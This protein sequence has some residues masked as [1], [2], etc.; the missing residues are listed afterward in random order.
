MIHQAKSDR[1]AVN[2]MA[3]A[4]CVGLLAITAGTPLSALAQ[5]TKALS[6]NDYKVNV[7]TVV[8]GL[9][10]PWG[11]AFLP[12]GR[13]LI[14][15][16][17]G[18]MR[19][20]DGGKLV[21]KAIDGLPKATEL[22]QGGMMDVAI[23]P[24]YAQNGWIYWTYNAVEAGL[25][26]TEVARGKLGGTKDAPRMTDV[27]VL[28]KMAPKSDR[29]FH[30]GS[31][32]VFDRDGYLF[33]TFG[34]RGD[35]PAK[36]ANQRSQLLGD[37]AGKSIRLFD[38]GRVPPDNPFVKTKD[39]KP[40]IFTLGNRN[41]QGAALNPVSGKLWTHE[42]GPQ[43]GDEVNIMVAGTNYG[44]PVITYGVNYGIGTKIG[45]GKEKSGMVQA[46]VLWVPSIAPSGMAFV[47]SDGNGGERPTNF[48]KWKGNALVGAL[49][50]QM[51]VR[52]TLD[53]D[54]VVAQE[55]LFTREVGRIRDVRQGPDGNIYLLTDSSDGALLRVE[56]AK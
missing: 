17:R 49:A 29:G 22:G 21:D 3:T 56:P 13:M 51:V 48:P 35:S 7:V 53:G 32:I 18:T 6:T 40:E 1:S 44:W 38:D 8:E 11:L 12:D 4:I 54:K 20:V 5:K 36:G 26:G 14:T 2:A 30:F 10:N 31:R 41:M 24:K 45:E 28:F 19:V 50:G 37:H 16:R 33:V 46:L 47:G 9:S 55:R 23:H 34:D 27:Q 52:I 43:G 25:H 15:E 39:A 42:H